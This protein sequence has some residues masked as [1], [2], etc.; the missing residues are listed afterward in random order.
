[1]QPFA[2]GGALD[3]IARMLGNAMTEK[4]GQQVI[5]EY[6]SGAGG[7]IGTSYVAKQRPDGYTLLINPGGPMTVAKHL[8]KDVDYETLR[9]FIPIIKITETPFVI[10]TSTKSLPMKTMA[11]LIAHAKANPEAVSVA[12]TG[13]GTLGH[14]AGMLLERAAGIKLR[15][16]PYRGTG[17]LMTDLMSGQVDMTINFFAG[18]GPHVDNGTLRVLAVG[19]EDNIPDV[20]KPF[21]TAKQAGVP[22]M[23]LS[24]WYGLYAPRDT[25]QDV[26]AR[27]Y[28]TLAE[29]LKTDDAKKKLGDL[30]LVTSGQNTEQLSKYI[31]E[32]DARLGALI[33]AVGLTPQ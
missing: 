21:P 17:Q 27:I 7:M 3:P 25:P 33:R 24:G 9:D 29:Y 4:F 32:E 12:N 13:N 14:L 5:M 6:R 16:V 20:L 2:A 23:Q 15:H 11:E 26:I 10:I 31:A 19:A 28:A 30:G 18:F 8:Y 22:D 1:V